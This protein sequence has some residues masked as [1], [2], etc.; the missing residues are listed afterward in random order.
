VWYF[1]TG[2]RDSCKSVD[3]A[4]RVDKEYSFSLQDEGALRPAS[5]RGDRASWEARLRAAPRVTEMRPATCP[6]QT[7]KL[8]QGVRRWRA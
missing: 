1:Y 2:A 4:P 8:C 3:G 6:K 7:G 5:W